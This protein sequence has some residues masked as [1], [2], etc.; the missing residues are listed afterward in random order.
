[1]L[2]SL[3]AGCCSDVVALCCV[4]GAGMKSLLISLWRLLEAPGPNPVRKPPGAC[5]AKNNNR[6]Y[7]VF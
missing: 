3:L 5:E 1:M 6:F 7:M 4:M 2:A